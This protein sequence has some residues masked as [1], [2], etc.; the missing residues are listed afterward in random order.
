AED[1][2]WELREPVRGSVDAIGPGD[3]DGVPGETDRVRPYPL[4]PKPVRR[5]LDPVRGQEYRA[6]P[7]G[8]QVRPVSDDHPGIANVRRREQVPPQVRV[9]EPVDL[10]KAD[11]VPIQHRAQGTAGGPPLADDVPLGVDPPGP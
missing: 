8:V 3:R 9:D 5:V 11:P 4:E 2:P 1:R 10:L 6:R 7:R